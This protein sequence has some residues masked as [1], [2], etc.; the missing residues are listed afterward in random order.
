MLS[1]AERRKGIMSEAVG[2]I[3]GYARDWIDSDVIGAVSHSL[4]RAHLPL[5]GRESVRLMLQSV[6]PDNEPSLALMRRAGFEE[7]YRSTHTIHMKG[8][9]VNAQGE[10]SE[11]DVP[12]Q[13][14]MVRLVLRLR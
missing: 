8:F 4:V 7:I 11:T 14:D 6:A 5:Y 13:V 1:P 2:A 10:T 3:L 12:Q 9:E